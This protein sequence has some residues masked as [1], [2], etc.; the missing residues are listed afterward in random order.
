MIKELD[1][2]FVDKIPHSNIERFVKDIIRQRVPRVTSVKFGK[3]IIY[4]NT[5][6]VSSEIYACKENSN[7]PIRVGFC[8]ADI[9]DFKC[10]IHIDKAKIYTKE[11]AKWVYDELRFLEGRVAYQQQNYNNETPSSQQY[12]N[13]YNSYTKITAQD[14]ISRISRE[15]EENLLK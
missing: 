3:W 11:W 10:R 12:R 15:M 8:H 13:E 2:K 4:P 1:I 9:D 6:H 5:M 14:E 7:T